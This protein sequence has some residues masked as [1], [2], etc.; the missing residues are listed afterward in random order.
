MART[1]K[2][3]ISFSRLTD[4][5]FLVMVNTIVG[6]MKGNAHFPSPVPELDDIENLIDDFTTK[7]KAARKRGSPED[8]ALKNES[9][10]ILEEAMQKL[11]YYVNSVANGQLSTLLSSGFPV[12]GARTNALIPKQMEGVKLSDGRQAGQVRLDFEKQP[13]ALIY[14]YTYRRVSEIE[15]EW[16]DRFV[17]TSSRGNVIAPLRSGYYYEAR[18]RAVNRMGAGDWSQVVK[19]LVR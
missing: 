2:V 18:V 7:L 1:Q 5:A 12:S 13:D 10:P 3:R 6:A 14:E 16:S 9:R 19:F 4:D 8:T 17:T 15:E 11:G